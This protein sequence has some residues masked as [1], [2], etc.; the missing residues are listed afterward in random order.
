M[1]IT[2]SSIA[3]LSV[4]CGLG[5]CS[6]ARAI[7]ITVLPSTQSISV[8]G[9]A[10][11]DLVISGLRNFA[12]PSLGAFDLDLTYNLS[13]LSA[14][15]LTFGSF[16][17]LGTFGSVQSFDISTPGLIH[18]DE[19]SLETSSDLNTFQPDTFTLSTLVF[20]GLTPGVSSIDFSFASLACPTRAGLR[21]AASLR[22]EVQ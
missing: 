3:L 9:S 16:L 8:G 14:S 2:R 7:S 10:S 13:V 22:A 6:E 21:S 5:V 19:V 17:D 12:S 18:L 4:I 20:V 1:R 15:S 11:V